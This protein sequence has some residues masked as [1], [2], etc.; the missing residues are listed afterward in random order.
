MARLQNSAKFGKFDYRVVLDD[1]IESCN[2]IER[3]KGCFYYR[4]ESTHMCENC[5][6]EIDWIVWDS[7]Q[8]KSKATCKCGNVASLEILSFN[9]TSR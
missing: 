7:K 9:A 1:E 3:V 6:L 4:T 2:Y 8:M 5:G